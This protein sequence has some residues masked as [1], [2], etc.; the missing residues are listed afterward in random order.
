MNNKSIQ[1]WFAV[2][3]SGFI[4][5]SLDEP[6]RNEKT[7]KW[8]SKYPFISSK[9]NQ[10]ISDLIEKTKINWDHEPECLTISFQ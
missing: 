10:E 7:G 8:D 1:V 4:V 9:V 3:K 2:N 5:L 6:K